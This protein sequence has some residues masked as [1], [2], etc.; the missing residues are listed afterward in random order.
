MNKIWH[1]LLH[2]GRF[3]RLI[4]ERYICLSITNI[5]CL[6]IIVKLAAASQPSIADLGG[7]FI[8]LLAYTGKK[9]L[10]KDQAKTDDTQAQAVA[11]LKV[12]VSEIGDR[13]G[14]IAAMVGIK[15]VKK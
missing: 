8:A 13:I 14:G 10:N 1:A 4:D 2:V 5:A 6:V 9:Q 7:L 11:D 15:T 12:K 3:L